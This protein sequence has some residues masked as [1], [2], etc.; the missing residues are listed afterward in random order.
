LCA[1]WSAALLLVAVIIAVLMILD[2][3]L[4]YCRL[5]VE[6]FAVLVIDH[7]G[8]SPANLWPFLRTASLLGAVV[9]GH[10]LVGEAWQAQIKSAVS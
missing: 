10:V 9:P 3:P 8:G 5:R 6:R 1:V 2:D 7:L 4:P